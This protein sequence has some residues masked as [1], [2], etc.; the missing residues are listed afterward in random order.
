MAS[1]RNCTQELPLNPLFEPRRI[2]KISLFCLFGK[3]SGEPEFQECQYGGEANKQH[4]PDPNPQTSETQTPKSV[5]LNPKIGISVQS[6][7]TCLLMQ[8]APYG[9]NLEGAE[10]HGGLGE[11]LGLRFRGIGF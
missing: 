4:H 5:I 2:Q 3:K 10:K 6:S 7:G 8:V 9:S 1:D 11:A